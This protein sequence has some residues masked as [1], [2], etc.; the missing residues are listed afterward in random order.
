MTTELTL[1]P[2]EAEMDKQE[3]AGF[4]YRK[5]HVQLE[6]Y[7]GRKLQARTSLER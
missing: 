5:E 7:D 4:V 3:G 2:S 6:A 1:P